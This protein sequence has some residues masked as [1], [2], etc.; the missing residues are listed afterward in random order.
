MTGE[1]SALT[2]DPVMRRDGPR[3]ESGGEVRHTHDRIGT[4]NDGH[5]ARNILETSV[6]RWHCLIMI[7]GVSAS[8]HALP[9]ASGPQ[10][11]PADCAA[12][13]AD[14]AR[15]ACYD[16][17]FRKAA[18]GERPA[19]QPATQADAAVTKAE[20]EGKFGLTLRALTGS[21]QLE[22]MTSRVTDISKRGKAKPVLTLE[23]GQRWSPIEAIDF[24]YFRPGDQI[25][26]RPAALGSFLAK[27]EDLNRTIR[28]RRID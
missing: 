20:A 16:A 18:P 2:V 17:S 4:P 15:L 14:A 9:A 3:R 21:S 8:L 27:K 23:N 12:I 13:E 6:N 1:S 11:D 25:T 10:G 24:N 7:L 5:R 28:V 22:Q 26:I 19:T